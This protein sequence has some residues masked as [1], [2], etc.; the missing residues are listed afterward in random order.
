M[1]LPNIILPGY[2]AGASDYFAIEQALRSQ[3]HPAL[4]VPLKWW[5]WLPTVGGRSIAPI[6][7][8]LDRAVEQVRSEYGVSKVNI[9]GHSA[10]GWL[11]R[12]YLGD[13]PYYDRIWKARDRVAKLVTLGT[14]HRSLEP[15]TRRNLGFVNDNYPDAFYEDVQYIC[16]AGRSVY[17]EKSLSKWVA[18]SSYELTCGIGNAWGDGITPIEAAHLKGAE[19]LVF[20][21]VNHSP[22]AGTWY[23]SPEIIAAWV[24]YL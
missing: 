1:R 5:E 2:L 22:K 16:V 4:V 24:K 3:G 9:I 17:G 20:D 13:Q 15:W 10:G 21:G 23:G 8:K 19:N 14:P 7:E 11:A 12:I 6:L 18:Y